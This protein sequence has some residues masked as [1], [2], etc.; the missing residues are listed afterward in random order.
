MSNEN[1]ESPDKDDINSFKRDRDN[2]Y[3]IFENNDG[4]N[5]SKGPLKSSMRDISGERNSSQQHKTVSFQES[6]SRNAVN[7]NILQMLN[8]QGVERENRFSV[9]SDRDHPKGMDIS[10]SPFERSIAN[11]K[12]TK[13]KLIDADIKAVTERK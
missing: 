11:F 12:A 6:Q 2:I 13:Q 7:T 1:T 10:L 3:S 9:D 5:G 4:R 8:T